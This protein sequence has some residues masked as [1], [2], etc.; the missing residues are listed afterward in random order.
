MQAANEG[1][2]E[3]RRHGR[4]SCPFTSTLALLENL[5]ALFGHLA[6]PAAIVRQHVPTRIERDLTA[7]LKHFPDLLP[8]A[9]NPRLH[10]GQRDS[11]HLGGVLLA[12]ALELDEG[13]RF[14][15]GRRQRRDEA[16]AQGGGLKPVLLV[17]AG[18]NGAGKTTVT[19]RLRAER[20]DEL[21][22]IAS[23]RRSPG[24]G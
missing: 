13:D 21:R 10:P 17:V 9:L 8:A 24:A 19:S 6:V 15:I 7:R 11:E 12:H 4:S 16:G 14:A 3:C 20:C 5:T 1:H 2:R 18:P 22:P 23:A